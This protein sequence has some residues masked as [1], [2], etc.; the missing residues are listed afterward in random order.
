MRPL[1]RISRRNQPGCACD[2]ITDDAARAA[3]RDS[4]EITRLLNIFPTAQMIRSWWIELPV[5]PI[6]GRRVV[7]S[8]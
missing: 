6:C 5:L 1:F 2:S 3:G 8:V 4:G 7:L